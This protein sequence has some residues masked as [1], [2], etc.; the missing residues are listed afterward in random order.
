MSEPLHSL[1]ADELN[2]SKEKA[3]TLLTAMLRE[4]QKRA[5]REGVRLPEFGTFRERNGRIT[6]EASESL[7]RAVNHRFEGLQSEDLATAPKE[8]SKEKKDQ[9]PSTITLGYQDSDW[10]P[11]NASDETSSESKD[12]SDTAEFEVPS[13][14]EAADTE[15]LQASSVAAGAGSHASASSIDSSERPM[16]SGS[17]GENTHSPSASSSNAGSNGDDGNTPSSSSTGGSDD[18]EHESLSE[19]WESDDVGDSSESE[20]SFEDDSDYHPATADPGDDAD[21]SDWSPSA[22]SAD[23]DMSEREA[24][25]E[26]KRRRQMQAAK[27]DSGGFRRFTFLL[28]LLLLGGAGWYILGEQ[29]YVQP[30]E[31]TYRAL[32]TD[33]QPHLES[34]PVVG[35]R[36]APDSTTESDASPADTSPTG[37]ASSTNQTA[38]T[39]GGQASEPGGINSDAGGW[40]IVVA[41]RTDRGAAESLVATYRSRFD[42]AQVPIDILAGEVNNTTRYR[43]GIGQF[44]TQ[45]QARDFISEFDS[46]LPEGAWPLQL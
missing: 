43:I 5:R 31:Q 3:E 19:I 12:E 25:M 44:D 37:D 18:F 28:V 10:S 42:D 45:S 16:S 41:S 29:G 27:D 23:A 46:E 11:L 39:E 38:S 34:L 33:L 13:A 15:E 21:I 17:K 7:A 6:F 20:F 8:Q 36:L 40:T 2:V 26:E 1:L 30:P 4:V 24:L 14:E 9:G 22:P 32:K 35:A